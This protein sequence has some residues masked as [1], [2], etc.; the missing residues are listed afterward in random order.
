[1]QRAFRTVRNEVEGRAAGRSRD[2]EAGMTTFDKR[3]EGFEKKFAIDEE[4]QIQGERPS[5][6]AARPV[7]GG[8]ARTLRRRSRRLRQGGGG[9]GF[10][11]GG[12]GRRVPQ[13]P[14]GSGCQ[15]RQ[16]NPISRF[17]SAMDELMAKAVQEIQAGN[18]NAARSVIA[19]SSRDRKRT[20]RPSNTAVFELSSTLGMTGSSAPVFA[21]ARFADDEQ[22]TMSS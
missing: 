9:G 6:Q 10:R 15:G 4:L 1:M 11:R 22:R 14:S 7:G 18:S 21:A 20:M 2:S 8:Q 19:G 3:E 5:Q 17:A 13:D 16:A 12:R